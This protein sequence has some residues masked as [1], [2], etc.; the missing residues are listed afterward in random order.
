MSEK[1]G[2]VPTEP[3]NVGVD[4]G[5]AAVK[6]AWYDQNGT[7]RTLS[8]PSR[9]RQGS[10]GIGSFGENGT[11]GGYE[12]DGICY[13]V[14]AEIGG[15]ETR[16][17]DYNLSRTARVLAH[18]ALI[19]AGFGGKAVRIASGL[20]LNR[21]F[22]GGKKNEERISR[23]VWNFAQPVRR[24]DE[25]QTA[26]IVQHNVFAQ[27]LT[28]AV[29]WFVEGG[30]TRPHKG[31][32]GV[33]DIGGQTID[34]SVVWL[35]QKG[36]LMTERDNLVTE[37]IGVLDVHKILKRQIMS[38][39]KVDDV[40]SEDLDRALTTGRIWIWT[41][42]HSV[43]D[44]IIEA[45]REVGEQL[46]APILSTFGKGISS[47]ENILFVGGGSYLFRDLVSM[48]PNAVVPDQPE[49]ANARGLLKTLSLF[50]GKG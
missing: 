15:S 17:P 25:G 18:H 16:I 3:L 29:D 37:D 49:F 47:L 20:P 9:V 26:K 43:E 12:T 40:S 44:E 21:Y 33:V 31:R 41:K 32:I 46:Q 19:Q 38:V 50:E 48:F 7:I 4:D 27:G 39:H 28:A 1:S 14:G 8:I 23:K 13:T 5:Y 11:V 35:G 36:E 10:L 24:M 2:S 30:K 42:D 6:V 22:E 45:V 34:I